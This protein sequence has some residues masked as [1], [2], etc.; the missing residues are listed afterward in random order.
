MVNHYHWEGRWFC[1]KFDPS[2]NNFFQYGNTSK[3]NMHF[4]YGIFKNFG[5]RRFEGGV[6]GNGTASGLERNILSPRRPTAAPSLQLIWV[7]S[8]YVGMRIGQVQSSP[9]QK[10]WF[11]VK[12]WTSND[13]RCKWQGLASREMKR[14]GVMVLVTVETR[15]DENLQA[16]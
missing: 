3:K 15:H 12:L 6:T 14:C 10:L 11:P 2:Y 1:Q 7:G 16:L 13:C 4:Q 5:W 9:H 8:A